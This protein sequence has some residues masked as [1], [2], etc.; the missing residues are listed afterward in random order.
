MRRWPLGPNYA[1][2]LDPPKAETPIRP[3]TEAIL[4]RICA[5]HKGE[6]EGEPVGPSEPGTAG[7][8]RGTT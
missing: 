7:E 8:A 4:Y 6:G 1:G 3:L 2:H 5:S